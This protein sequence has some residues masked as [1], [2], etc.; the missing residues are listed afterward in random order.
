M[1]KAHRH[2]WR[3]M[4]RHNKLSTVTFKECRDCRKRS[5]TRPFVVFE[6]VQS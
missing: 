6:K 5:P 3:W 4:I 1:S 2:R